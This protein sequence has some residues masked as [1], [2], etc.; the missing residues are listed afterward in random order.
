MWNDWQLSKYHC[1]SHIQMMLHDFPISLILFF[2]NSNCFCNSF[3]YPYLLKLNDNAN[4][5]RLHHQLLFSLVLVSFLYPNKYQRASKSSCDRRVISSH[6]S[7]WRW[8]MRRCENFVVFAP[9]GKHFW[10]FGPKKVDTN[11]WARCERGSNLGIFW[12]HHLLSYKHV[13]LS[14]QPAYVHIGAL[15]MK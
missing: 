8:C 3:P 4:Y 13:Y 2:N 10:V 11:D 1:L 5:V 14:E 7:V 15:Q 6:W 9:L 12:H